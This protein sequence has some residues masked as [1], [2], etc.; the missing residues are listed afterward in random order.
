[1][2]VLLA[3][4]GAKPAAAQFSGAIQTTV[5]DGTTVNGNLYPS[6]GKVYFTGGPQN[7]KANGLP[8]GTYYFQVTDP[9]GATLLSNDPA[10]CRQVVVT[11]GKIAGA[12]DPVSLDVE[13]A[14]T[15]L[16]TA[17]CEHASSATNPSN[18]AVP[19][20]LGGAFGTCA[21]GATSPD[22]FCDTPNPGGE[23]KMWLIAQSSAISGCKPTVNP[24]Q[25]SL[26]FDSKCTKTDNF[27]IVQPAIAHVAVCKFNDANG[28]GVLNSGELPISGWPITATVPV[29]SFVTLRSDNH[30]GASVTANTDSTGCVSFAASGILDNTQVTVKLT[31]GSQT[32]WTQTAPA[33]GVYDDSG[34]P[35]VSGPTTVSGAVPTSGLP[36]EGGVIAVN[37]GP[38]DSVTAPSF[39]NTNPDCPDCTILGT[40]TV[41][42]TATPNKLFT[43]G[44]TKSVDKT[45]LDI[46]AGGSAT[47]NYT[48]NVTHDAGTGSLLTGT[49]TLI[50][51]DGSSPS[52]TLD[53]I[54]AVNNGGVCTI[55][56]PNSALYV[57][58]VMNLV[59][60]SF[61]QVSLPYQCSYASAPAPSAGTN[62]AT[63]TDASNPSIHFTG[64]ATFDFS[65]A[66]VASDGTVSVTDTIS[67]ALG[68][69]SNTDPSPTTF[70]YSHTFTGDPA[71]TCTTHNNTATATTNTTATTVSASQSVKVCVGGA[72]PTI[73]TTPNK[74]SATLG[75][76][77]VTL[78][79]T[80]VLSG[81]TSPTG[82]ITFTLVFNGGT[83]DTETVSVNGN[84]TYSTPTGF[85]VST[86]RSSAGTYQWNAVYSGDS[87]NNAA[88]ETN[89]PSE[90]VVVSVP[91]QPS[92]ATTPSPTSATLGNTPITLKDSAVL[93][94][95]LNATGTIT[96]TLVFN[97][98]TVDTETVA[99]SGA[100]TY[101]TPT[102]FTLPIA[103]SSAGTYQ[104]NA[105]YSGDGNN[106]SVS[107]TNAPSEQVVVSAPP[108]PTIATTPNP[109]SAT[110]GTTPITLKDS[111]V[112]TG[113]LNATGTITFTLVFNGGTI[114]TETVA[115][116]GAGTY[117][118]PTGFTLPNARSSA[119][120]YQWNATYS[121]DGNNN[122][123][124]ET[125]AAS[126]QV[127]V[128]APPQPS[129][130]T[131]PNPKSATLGATPIT[132]R[133]SAVLTGGL[134]A[135]G[136]ITFTLVFNGGPTVDTETVAVNGAGT[137]NT[138][139]G[140]TLPVGRDA[141]TTYQWNA[142]YSGDGNN[143]SVSEINA[144]SEQV[145]VTL[146][147]PT[148]IVTTPSPANVTLGNTIITLKDSAVLSGGTN[149]TG[150][151]TF[152]LVFNS[153][154]IDTETV[155][156]NGDGTYTTPT[157][158]TL[159][160]GTGAAGIYQWN[161][162]YSG[163][164][165][166]TSAS[167][168]SDPG[169]Q[170]TVAPATTT[171]S[172]TSTTVGNTL[173]DVAVL[174]GPK[175]T[176]MLM[177]GLASQGQAAPDPQ[178]LPSAQAT[179]NESS[180]PSELPAQPAS[181][182]KSQPPSP[183]TDASTASTSGRTLRVS[184][185][186]MAGR[187]VHRVDPV[188]PPE[189][190]LNRIRGDV[191]LQTTIGKDGRIHDVKV[192]SGPKELIDAAV[193]AVEQWR[194]R[195]FLVKGEPVEVKTTIKIRFQM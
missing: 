128:S 6:K 25:V 50:N 133:D 172:P 15:P 183:A 63:A 106:N 68:T 153:A 139:T 102:G 110:L 82:T 186:V 37:L 188:Y 135:T 112:L 179:P 161:A 31:E 164:K 191:L 45:E 120:T 16:D 124:S 142:V 194:Y 136:T 52:I 192:V 24:D 132:L 53:V 167:E 13:P 187:I 137:Y 114:D 51:A 90:Q 9:S 141:A 126:E 66:T 2:L 29:N 122:A 157:G 154:T 18:G 123:A 178:A 119:G 173:K 129:I 34:H 48:V 156:V 40:V 146:P 5:P 98:G 190:K 100:G 3:V 55:R 39:G 170:V 10:K 163:D 117:N 38:G 93:T 134:N 111:A 174:S 11:G 89:A 65:K 32:K 182:A 1:M 158:F 97:G 143:S 107:E 185:R 96:F 8:D 108:Q 115:V 56:D 138:P 195:P 28:D 58:E 105:T 169:E 140:F 59:L 155:A 189:A 84:G 176:L 23:Y 83:V 70:R 101:N 61:T 150:T 20:Q 104:W 149:P 180:A 12:F 86:A 109:T 14:G 160:T 113:G 144:L 35:A 72:S 94:G 17:N 130:A 27:K 92:I 181:G 43:W 67:G 44:I 145:V 121:G 177:D 42:K 75:S 47:F 79:D 41:I 131:T 116:N 4:A 95:G 125:N 99:V 71:A 162:I 60:N 147:P 148:A 87:N 30:V 77:P 69:V 62:T 103:R 85:T 168:I 46:T 171:P 74:T 19:V 76:T 7:L 165:I 118:T 73:A 88:S 54:D 49:I 151:I 33:N 36:A 152:T 159:P 127:V 26:T 80:A 175:G 22:I 166:N 64:T 91:P 57:S 184:Q 21:T 193:G 81:G 78:A